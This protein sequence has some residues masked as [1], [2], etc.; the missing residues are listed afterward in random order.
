MDR[1]EDRMMDVIICGVL[2]ALF[3]WAYN[4]YGREGGNNEVQE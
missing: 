3:A 2:M 4:K 1:K